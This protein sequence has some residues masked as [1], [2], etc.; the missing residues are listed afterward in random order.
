MRKLTI[1]GRDISAYTIVLRREPASAERTAAAFLQRVITQ[2]CGVTLPVTEEAEI[3]A[4]GPAIRVGTRPGDKRVKWDGFRIAAEDGDLY[5]DGNLPRGTLYAAYDFAERYLDC[6]LL[7][8]DTEVISAEGS[9]EVPVG[10]DLVDNPAFEARCFDWGGLDDQPEAAARGRINDCDALNE[11]CGG[12]AGLTGG[13]HTLAGLCPPAAYFPAHP[14]YYSLW[15]GRRIPAGNGRDDAQLCLTNPEVLHIVTENA[16]EKLRRDPGARILEIS[17]CDNQR[18]CQCERCAAVDAEEGSHAG[19]MIRFVNAVA[20]AV[21]REFPDVWVR[22][23][24]YQ[25]TRKPPRLTR[26][27]RNVMV[28]Y[29]TIEACFRHA[30]TDGHCRKNAGRFARELR[31][32]RSAADQLSVWDYVTN[33]KSYIAPFP[34]LQALRENMRLFAECGAVQVFEEDNGSNKAGGAY[35]E[36]RAYLIGKLLW[37]PY[38]SEEAYQAHIDTFLRGYYGP[39]WESVRRYIELEHETTAKVHVR[40]FTLIDIADAFRGMTTQIDQYLRD[41]YE[42]EAYQPVYPDSALDGL[43]R[44]LDEALSLWDRAAA[45]AET[46]RQRIHI[47]RS[48]LSL[49]YLKLFCTVHDKKT[50]SEAERAAYEAE[51][52]AFRREK[53]EFGFHYNIWTSAARQE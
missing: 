13:C 15:E 42:A 25:Y 18:Y 47:R 36:L 29:C 19:T 4:G 28:R 22:T 44:R 3:R 34:N 38:M 50:M 6:R 8:P 12:A 49:T 21:E 33:Y 9:A 35:P 20:E 43:V 40:C 31:A 7:A 39:G 51:V 52:E 1:N 16:L 5:L 17:Q 41:R 46:D 14:E 37:D 45:L 53:A 27:R 26:A 30:L 10:L 11:A 32:W 23:F 24:A 48:R 2:A